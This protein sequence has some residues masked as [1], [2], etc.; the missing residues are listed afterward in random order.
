SYGFVQPHLV[1]TKDREQPVE[2]RMDFLEH[3]GQEDHFAITLTLDKPGLYFYYFDLHA[4]D[5]KVF[6]GLM[7]EGYPALDKEGPQWQLTVYH[8]DFVTPGLLKGGT[9]YQIFPD[10]FY[11]GDP[12]K[13]WPFPER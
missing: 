8:P 6:R 12:N 10:R 7:E 2:Y 11:E 3:A 13:P 1:L 9:F 4:W 5:R